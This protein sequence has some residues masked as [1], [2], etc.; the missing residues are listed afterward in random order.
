MPQ[1]ASGGGGTTPPNRPGGSGPGA[2]TGPSRSQSTQTRRV[3]ISAGAFLLVGVAAYA[4][5]LAAAGGGKD[6]PA[7]LPQPSV[8]AA[9]GKCVVSYA[10]YS[11]DGKRF[12]ATVT[13]ANRDKTAIKNWNLWFIMQG[14]QTVSGG[15]KGSFKLEQ[16]NTAVTVKSTASLSAQ[17]SVTL[18]LSGRYARSNAAPMVFQLG[19]QTCETYVSG[20]PGEPSRPVQRL[21]NGQIRLGPPTTTPAPGITIGNNGIVTL[22]PIVTGTK[23]LQPSQ[24]TTTTPAVDC[25]VNPRPAPPICPTPPPTPQTQPPTTTDPTTTDPTTPPPA[26]TSTPVDP[27]DTDPTTVEDDGGTGN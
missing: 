21:S 3:L 12:D 15:G 16:E 1:R 23:T 18:N 20:K 5:S 9:S 14:D 13:V 17:K 22:G 8:V 25:N 2:S 11:D 6:G 10:V 26:E 7:V 4:W 24:T 27:H 19:G